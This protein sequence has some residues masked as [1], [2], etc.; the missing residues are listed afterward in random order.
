MGI[1][2]CRKFR[3]QPATRRIEA[4]T[5]EHVVANSLRRFVPSPKPKIASRIKLWACLSIFDIIF[6]FVFGL[7]FGPWVFWGPFRIWT[8]IYMFLKLYQKSDLVFKKIHFSLNFSAF[9]VEYWGLGKIITGIFKI[10]VTRFSLSFYR[11]IIGLKWV[12][13]RTLLWVK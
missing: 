11:C 12:M 8:F 10:N 7:V 5:E 6:H 13:V 1:T 3:L 9:W 2:W 4:W